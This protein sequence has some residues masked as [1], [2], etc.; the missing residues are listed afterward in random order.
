MKKTF[1]VSILLVLTLSFG[2]TTPVSATEN[3]TA[4]QTVIRVGYTEKGQMIQTNGYQFSG[5]GFS[6]LQML[7]AYTGWQYEF[8]P[9]R[10]DSRIQDLKNGTIDLLCDVSEDEAGISQLILSKEACSMHYALLCAKED[11]DSVY[12]NEYEAMDGKRIA[13]N[14][15]R[16]MERMLEDFS[17]DAQI[18]YTPVYCSSFSEM[19][20]AID[21][22]RADLL[23]S[24]NQRDLTG[25]KYVAKMGLRDQ[26]FATSSE[27]P[28]IMEQL[29]FADRQM[30]IKQ[31]FIIAVLYETY[32]GRPSEVL[33]GTTREEYE[34]IE[35]RTPVR[36]VCDAKSFPVEYLDEETGKY[37]GIYADAMALIAEE[38]G[39]NF[40]FI[41]IAEFKDSWSMLQN[42]EVDMSAGMYLDD[43]L[44]AKHGLI[45]SPSHINANYTMI[46]RHN[47]TLEGSLKL[48]LPENYVGVQAFVRDS[49]PE[50]EIIPARNNKECLSMVNT[51]LADGTLIN[52]VFLQTAYNL[53]NYPN[54]VVLPM[55]CIDIPISCAFAGPNA[56][57][58][59][60]IVTKAIRKIPADS[61][62][63]CSIENSVKIVYKPTSLDIM[64][65]VLPYLILLFAASA[66]LYLITLRSRER[67]YHHMAMTDSL[68]GLWNDICFRKEAGEALANNPKKE[69]QLISLDLAHFRYAYTD[70]GEKTADRILQSIAK[71]LRTSFGDEAMCAREMGDMFLILTQPRQDL[72]D[73]PRELEKELVLYS[74]GIEQRY[75]PQLKFGVCNIPA[76]EHR[77][78]INEYIDHA[79]TARKSVKKNPPSRIALFDQA[80]EAEISRQVRIEKKMEAALEQGHFTVYFQPKYLLESDTL[81]GAEALVRW[82]DPEE[83]MIFPDAFI[84]LFEQNGFIV[85]LDFFVYEQTLKALAKWRTEGRPDIVVSVNVS[86]VHI[87]VGNFLPRLVK[88]AD[89]YQIPHE[90]LELELTETVLG[91]Q[92]QDTLK[93][94]QSCKAEGFPI[95]IDDFGSGYSSLNLLKELPVDVLK[96]DREFLNETDVSEK[97]S[98]IIRQIVKMAAKLR[99]RTLCEGVETRAQA[100]FLKEIGC[101]LAQG[102]LYSRPVPLEDFEK[103]F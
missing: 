32:Y 25:Y 16:R 6:Y 69:Y 86:R 34:F 2:W 42:G 100:E 41:P 50:W 89:R 65:S 46:L 103:L 80:M 54:L 1:W 59:C 12:F 58:L 19:E 31:P 94:I 55:H 90:L 43:A 60:Q 79:I 26:F 5:Y 45:S 93:F 81:A 63:N 76:D 37:S 21:E 101:D 57:L 91:G 70:F 20:R 30:K 29:D 82:K 67:H 56:E 74:N 11:D 75:K 49:Y 40:E 8:V 53:N 71:R 77:L 98:I 28:E 97:S 36:V 84:P 61:F 39:L 62:E 7:A 92:R 3:Q 14:K 88:L 102:Y 51:G 47:K 95:S 99:I 18:S 35:S 73:I 13:V 44:K 66:I 15:S 9:V 64:R 10:E 72:A 85:Q 38:S 96:I 17:Q 4:E 48:A 52:S 33:T 83:G 68:T 27:H 24:S 22:G 87:G 23:V 78:P